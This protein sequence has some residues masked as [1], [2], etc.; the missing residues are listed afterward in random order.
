MTAGHEHAM[1]PRCAELSNVSY[2]NFGLSLFILVGILVSYLP[3]HIRI[4]SRRSSYGLSPWFVLLGTT[5]GTCA[6]AN[7]LVLPKSRL[8]IG[9]CRQVDEFA[10]VAGLLGIA[11]VGVQWSCFTVILLL[12]LIF[13][14]RSPS[15]SS[16]H[17]TT[18][19][20]GT[21]DHSLA[22]NGIGVNADI[23]V[24]S[25]SSSSIY[26][27]EPT[28]TTKPLP[29]S[30]QTALLVTLL[31]VL[32]AIIILILS[33]YYVYLRPQHSQWWANFLGIFSTILASIQY[34]PQI[35]T[36]WNLKRVGSLSIPMMCIQTPGS[37]VWAGS[38]AKRFGMEGWSA[39][40]VYLVTGCLQGS[41]LVMGSY[42]E[43]MFR[44]RERQE[45]EGRIAYRNGPS[46]S[47]IESEIVGDHGTEAENAHEDAT[48][49]TPLLREG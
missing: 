29:H 8:D 14:P 42:F 3:Q 7:I 2:T 47:G 20:S 1:D 4:I 9:C 21:P 34:F 39:W 26:P 10:C 25:P 16:Q 38:L 11:Q 5:S 19:N 44:R 35:W 37:F 24:D 41:L 15:T 43:I 46:T 30:Y 33:V 23:D 28:D 17:T 36:T 32:H 48:E 18:K 6:F 13:F 40:G 22:V 45:L 27:V 12:F 31:S 49:E